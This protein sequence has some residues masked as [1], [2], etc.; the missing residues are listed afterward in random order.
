MTP[1]SSS[2][3]PTSGDCF[4]TS[5]VNKE[6]IVEGGS[7]TSAP[8][9]MV[10][11]ETATT[12]T[13]SA[14]QANHCNDDK[15]H[16]ILD[17]TKATEMIISR[18]DVDAVVEEG[19]SNDHHPVVSDSDDEKIKNKQD[20]RCESEGR[21]V[22]DGSSKKS[23]VSFDTIQIREYVRELG[24]NPAVSHGPPLTIGWEYED[25]ATLPV[26]DYETHRGDRRSND[27]MQIPGKKRELLLLNETKNTSREINAMITKVRANRSQR[28]STVALL[29]FE[30]WYSFFETVGRRF[31]RVRLLHHLLISNFNFYISSSMLR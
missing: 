17:G 21:I 16:D 20:D 31:R 22:S 28:Q 18:S 24:D 25:V 8:T 29:E 14:E 12:T 9:K 15:E 10:G 23:S 13:S 26:E 6:T 5:A 3:S 1:R 27:Q 19:C 2:S 4:T 30:E 11:W 7:T